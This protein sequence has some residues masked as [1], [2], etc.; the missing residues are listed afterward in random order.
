MEQKILTEEQKKVIS[1][2]GR[3]QLLSDFY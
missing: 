1:A 3:E 2:V